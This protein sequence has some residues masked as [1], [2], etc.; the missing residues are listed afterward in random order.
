MNA[1][2]SYSRCYLHWVGLF[3]TGFHC[4]TSFA[5]NGDTYKPIKRMDEYDLTLSD[6]TILNRDLLFLIK[7]WLANVAHF[8]AV[9]L[10][11]YFSKSRCIWELLYILLLVSMFYYSDPSSEPTAGQPSS[12]CPS[13][14]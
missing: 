2:F 5:G 3:V 10:S 14:S 11:F 1:F 6:G 12:S 8:I 13:S 9:H 4:H 7:T